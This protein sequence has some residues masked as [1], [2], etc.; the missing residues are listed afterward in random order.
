LE[1]KKKEVSE[2]ENRCLRSNERR[3]LRST[4]RD[5]AKKKNS[6]EKKSTHVS[7]VDDGAD[8]E[9]QRHAELVSGGTT[10]TALGLL[11]VEEES[12]SEREKKKKR[13]ECLRSSQWAFRL[14]S[15]TTK[16][17]ELFLAGLASR[18]LFSAS[19]SLQIAAKEIAI[20]KE[21]LQQSIRRGGKRGAARAL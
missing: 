13:G 14:P 19:S 21:E 6:V 15:A 7:A 16:A 11:L 1:E 9:T 10:A 5:L 12:R 20:C 17:W 3:R 2:R 18:T 4:T 8:G